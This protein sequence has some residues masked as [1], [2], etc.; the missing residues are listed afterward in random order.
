MPMLIPIQLCNSDFDAGQVSMICW[1]LLGKALLSSCP[2]IMV[3]QYNAIDFRTQEYA[4][5][6]YFHKDYLH[7]PKNI[8]GKSS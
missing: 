8:I 2:K 3:I 1:H 6:K 4:G 7:N 5:F